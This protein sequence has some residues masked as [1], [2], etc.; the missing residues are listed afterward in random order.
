MSAAD[1]LDDV[2]PTSPAVAGS[3][4]ADLLTQDDSGPAR[5]SVRL[6]QGIPPQKAAQV[7]RLK[8]KT[9][10]PSD[11][12][13]RNADALQTQSDNAAITQQF[14]QDHPIVTAHMADDPHNAALVAP[15]ATTWGFIERQFDY[16]KN[17]IERGGLE[18]EGSVRK[19]LKGFGYAGPENETRINEIDRRLRTDMNKPAPGPISG[20]F[21][22]V[23]ESSPQMALALGVGAGWAAAGAPASVGSAAAWGAMEFGNAY[24]DFSTRKDAQGNPKMNADTARGFAILSGVSQ[25]ALFAVGG[26]ILDEIPGMK[27]LAPQGL[28]SVIESTSGFSALKTIAEDIGRTGATMGGYSGLAS[29]IH[30]ASGHLAEMKADG[31]LTPGMSPGE[32]IARILPKEDL[33]AAGRAAIEGAESGGVLGVAGGG[34][35]V[36]ADYRNFNSS[37]QA[38]ELYYVNQHMQAVRTA[39]GWRALGSA[40]AGTQ[41][42]EHAPDQV[43]RLVSK[44]TPDQHVFIPM[45]QWQTYWQ[46]QKEDPRAVF[47]ATVGDTTAYDESMRTGAD[48]Q[49]PAAKYA[50]MI[51]PSDHNE[52]F[53][54]HL[55][56]EPVAMTADEAQKA[57]SIRADMEKEEAKSKIADAV[58]PVEQTPVEQAQML[59]GRNALF[60]EPAAVGMSE[61][62]AARY[63]KAIEEAH[64]QAQEDIV[65]RIADVELK[66]KS[67]SWL[68]ER[69][70]I[71]K[72]VEKDSW[73]HKEFLAKEILGKP[74]QTKAITE[75]RAA[76]ERAAYTQQKSEYEAWRELLKSGIKPDADV[77]DEIKQLPTWMKNKAGRGYDEFA[78]EAKEKGLLGPNE[79]FF[80]KLR[81]I[82]K[83]EKPLS[84]EEF[85]PQI[86][87]ELS[88]LKLS[89]SDIEENYPEVSASE[90]K[91][92]TASEGGMT[93]DEAATV[94]GFNS[95]DELL[96]TLRTTPK[97]R[98]WISEETDRRMIQ[99]HPEPGGGDIMGQ[100]MEAVH[101]DKR[102]QVLRLELEHLASNDFAVFKGLVRTLGRRIPTIKEVRGEAEDIVGSKTT[103]ETQPSLYQRAE[104]SAS[105]EAQDQFLRGD[106]QKAFEA[107]KA[108]LLNHELYRAAVDAKEQSTKDVAYAKRFDNDSSRARIGKAGGTYLEQIDAIRQQFDFSRIT[109]K[110]MG[111]R[112]SLRD[113][114]QEQTEA[115]YAPT[116]PA[117][118]LEQSNKRS[119]REMS[120]AELHSTVDAMRNI[121]HLAGL[122][123]D[124]LALSKERTFDQ[125]RNDIIEKL[126]ARYDITDAKLEKPIDLHPDFVEKVKGNL[127]SFGAWRTRM[128]P[129]FEQ[130][131]MHDTIFDPLNQ[132]EDF[133]TSERRKAVGTLKDIFSVYS[134]EERAKFGRL[135][136]IPELEGSGLSP[137]LNKMEMIMTLLHG[138]NE[139]NMFEVM[140]GYK[141]SEAQ[142]RG[143]WS[144]LEPRDLELA[145]KVWDFVDSYWPQISKQ[146]R[147]LNGLVPDKVDGRPL[148]I[149]LADGST[150]HLE[151]GYFPLVYD[152]DVSWRT[153]ALGQD[154]MV[155]DMFPSYVSNTATRHNWTQARVGGG[156][157]SPSLKF[158]VLT[159]HIQDV[160]HD[161]AY[162]KPVIDIYKVLND[163]DVRANIQAGP[164]KGVYAQMNPWIKRVAGDRQWEPMGPFEAL[165]TVRSN[166]TV[167]ELGFKVASAMVHATSIFPAIQELGASY[168][169]QGMKAFLDVPAAT[170]FM[171]EKSEFMRSRWEDV[172][173][174][175][176]RSAASDLNL[177]NLDTGF[178]AEMKAMSPLQQRDAWIIMRCADIAVAG[179]T[180]H[181]AYLKAM[182][183]KTRGIVA[184]D[185]PAAVAYAD[186]LVRD[187]KG[188]GA[189]KDLAPIQTVGGSFG[190]LMTMFM[191]QLNVI[192]NQMLGAYRQVRVDKDMGKLAGAAVM[193]WFVPAVAAQL[194]RGRIPKDDENWLWWAGKAVA[195]FPLEVMPGGREL[196]DAM[197]KGVYR[198][199]PVEE[200]VSTIAKTAKNVI[201]KNPIADKITGDESEW[202]KKDYAD[203]MM[204]LGYLKGLP[205]RQIVQSTMRLHGWM[206]GEEPHDNPVGGMVSVITGSKHE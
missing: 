54:Q 115:G 56:S 116:V 126:Q 28:R 62:K 103:A 195:K 140:R 26:K 163:E 154:A 125:L 53:S 153:A 86:V 167:A 158:N 41:M 59:Q 3:S 88:P 24:Q 179:P 133:K 146:E 40:I 187:T 142:L 101:N 177:I 31:S 105:R 92:M 77:A 168:M 165:R 131:G 161:L 19:M 113:W 45:E 37:A 16:Q 172:G 147:E 107:K 55:R 144:H 97:R 202:T 57:V 150:H 75:E 6:S 132:A 123:N 89:R 198:M 83:P 110:E 100:A 36:Y 35:D 42:N 95:G 134:K 180:W 164:G 183:G 63:G 80:Q 109:L 193:T 181:G 5:E 90:L 2:S 30:S 176:I 148:D 25:G 182:D 206:S 84:A 104:A 10:L 96:Y 38:K 91:G 29:L 15:D 111:S 141:M 108:E 18:T 87:R 118:L 201:E 69:D 4:V 135:T 60:P 117:D 170:K 11:F 152:K 130:L 98:D 159:N 23:V 119:W 73:G 139:G 13:S 122:K 81:T 145:Q 47:Q 52:F 51:A 169:K 196:V 137:N 194:W 157:Q 14:S 189:A 197:D 171:W 49:I 188:N 136:Y 1:L 204:T 200:A 66:K 64:G 175:D 120:N 186:R 85:V 174:R 192:D 124:L 203:A 191:T 48:L 178:W 99:R 67:A 102:S 78:Q 65:R 162:R 155:K 68:A 205:T 32:I 82:K 184:G 34:M 33:K 44:M 185:E 61:E 74:V 156:G 20:V 127:N 70:D 143:I 50:S 46:G 71:E 9:G 93:A 114:V 199:S 7:L 138:G 128:E 12:V 94:L 43:E 121:A 129:L 22:H 166:M 190:K 173:D 149:K 8:D 76:T 72:S 106:F 17:Q 112:Q 39:E 160:I 21:G 79:D 58:A 151:G 27:M